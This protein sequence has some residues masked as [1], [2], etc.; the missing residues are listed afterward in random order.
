MTLLSSMITVKYS[1][2]KRNR[3]LENQV[4]QNELPLSKCLLLAIHTHFPPIKRRK[5]ICIENAHTY[6]S[7]QDEQRLKLNHL[8]LL[9]PTR[10][11][12][13]KAWKQFGITSAGLDLDLGRGGG[14]YES[15]YCLFQVRSFL[16]Q[17]LAIGNPT[18]WGEH[19]PVAPWIRLCTSAM[20][21][22]TVNEAD[23]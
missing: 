18:V 11:S 13:I 5:V 1:D 19:G 6:F 10:P 22:Q 8:Y 17:L 4:W 12:N 16:T 3:A 15:F 9:H 2:K 20:Q 23:N 21:L 14:S 7:P